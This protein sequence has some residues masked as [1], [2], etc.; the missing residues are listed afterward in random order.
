VSPALLALPTRTFNNAVIRYAAELNVGVFFTLQPEKPRGRLLETLI[1]IQFH[2]F[3][4]GRRPPNY[5]LVTDA[6][7]MNL[8]VSVVG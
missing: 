1:V 5:R 4:G 3:C 7:V 2:L 8:L 6:A